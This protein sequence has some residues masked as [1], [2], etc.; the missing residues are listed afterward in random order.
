VAVLEVRVLQRRFRQAKRSIDP[1]LPP[2]RDADAR[3]PPG[4]VRM[5]ANRKNWRGVSRKYT[6]LTAQ[7]QRHILL[8]AGRISPYAIATLL[9][10]DT[11][12]V[13]NWIFN[14]YGTHVGTRRNYPLK[15]KPVEREKVNKVAQMME[16]SRRAAA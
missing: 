16:L 13:A 5:R 2:L 3:D 12:T 10:R 9:G 1:L 6:A 15:R 4:V 14:N 8:N 7:E 11:K